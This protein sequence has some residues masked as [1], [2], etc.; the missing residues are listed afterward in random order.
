MKF[1]EKLKKSKV[2]KIA[3]LHKNWDFLR[4]WKR[5][6]RGGILWVWWG[7]VLKIVHSSVPIFYDRT[8]LSQRGWH[9]MRTPLGPQPAPQQPS[10][11]WKAKPCLAP[12]FVCPRLGAF[13][14]FGKGFVYGFAQWVFAIL[15]NPWRR[16]EMEKFKRIHKG[17]P[18]K[19]AIYFSH[20]ILNKLSWLKQEKI[21]KKSPSNFTNITIQNSQLQMVLRPNSKLQ[22]EAVAFR[23]ENSNQIKTRTPSFA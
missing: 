12:I 6:E 21:E 1:M 3:F 19:I 17:L 18:R 7:R 8:R 2:G 10:K 14:E 9:R 22:T 23:R 5:A 11:N 15:R 13:G 4:R 20:Q 16:E